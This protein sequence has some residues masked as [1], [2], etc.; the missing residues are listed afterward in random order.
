MEGRE[1]DIQ[2]LCEQVLGASLIPERGDCGYTECPF[3]LAEG[4]WDDVDMDEIKHES[5][6]AFLIAKDLST[7]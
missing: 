7:K 3:C 5:T 2:E 4:G 6:C 1:K